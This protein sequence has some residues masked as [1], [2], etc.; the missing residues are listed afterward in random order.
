MSSCTSPSET[1]LRSFAA[2]RSRSEPAFGSVNRA[3]G[4]SRRW[5]MPLPVPDGRVDGLAGSLG[6]PPDVCR[7]LI[8]R[9]VDSTE[10]A[11]SFLR[12]HLSGLRSPADLPDLGPAVERIEAAILAGETILVHGDYDADG[13]SAAA[14]LTLGLSELGGRVEAFVPHRTRDGYDLSEAGLERATESGASLIVTADCGV[15]A[16]SA[17][18]KAATSGIDVVVTDHHRPGK[19]LPDAV[20]LVN[21]L[22]ADSSYGFHG[23]AGVGV[24]FKVL[25]ALYERSTIAAP[26]LNQHLDL[27][28]I[29]T[30]ADQMPLTDENRILVRA[31][32]RALERTRKP[33]L[34]ALLSHAGVDGDKGIHA[35]QISFR[36]A[37]RLNSVGRMAEADA[38]LELLLTRDPVAAERLAAHLERQNAQRRQTDSQVFEEVRQQLRSRFRDDDRA[39]VLWGDGWHP[40]VIGIVASRLVERLHRP[41][42]VIAFDG[43]VGRG[44]GRSIEGFHLFEALRE[45]ESLLDR[46]GG[47]RLAAGLTVRRDRVEELA[48]RLR[49]VAERELRDREPIDELRLDLEI[50]LDRVNPDLLRWLDHLGPFGQGNPP[51]V[52][53]VR[54]VHLDRPGRVGSDGAH[55]RVALS[56]GEDRVPAIGFGLGR[57]LQ[58]ARSMSHADVAIELAENRWNGRAELQ[59][60]VLDF[61]PTEP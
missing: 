25:A 55:L 26:L 41:S 57:R 24:A 17:V 21:P 30:V 36:I 1:G 42:V 50:S 43:D 7:I 49:Q 15:T 54:R 10:E 27:V 11:R 12:P 5:I 35:Q 28:A 16:V 9:G 52:L 56:R 53:M 47:H 48:D 31:G 29:G 60:R 46:F 19:R 45:C 38:G 23:L 44:S 14:L 8:R 33:G 61:R 59:A 2:G 39:V 37:P 13:M 3:G 20:A 18:Q 32:L 40:G 34:R 22:R 58:E 6:L 4:T 51:P